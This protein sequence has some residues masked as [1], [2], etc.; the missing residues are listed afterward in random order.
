MNLQ[1]Q[2]TD[3]LCETLGLPG[4]AT[5]YDGLAQSAAKN[6][7]SYSDYLE[8]CLKAEQHSRQ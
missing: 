4:L 5:D 3:E 6:E 1:A 2:R 7:S 8:Q